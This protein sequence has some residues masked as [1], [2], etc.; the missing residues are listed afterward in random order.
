MKR[1]YYQKWYAENGRYRLVIPL[2]VRKLIREAQKQVI[3][4]WQKTQPE[5]YAA[6]AALGRAI[7]EG[8]LVKPTTC[9]MCGKSG[10]L[11]PDQ[12]AGLIMW[13]CRKCARGHSE[14]RDGKGKNNCEKT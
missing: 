12:T 9:E 3:E 5:S 8:K 6:A 4:D 1:N 7:H 13:Q 10:R 2:H 14:P 11:V